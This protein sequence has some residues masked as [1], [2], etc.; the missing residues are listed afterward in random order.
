[1]FNILVPSLGQACY[2][3]TTHNMLCMDLTFVFE[4]FTSEK[5]FKLTRFMHA[6]ELSA[7]AQLNIL[8]VQAQFDQEKTDLLVKMYACLRVFPE[9][10]LLL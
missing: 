4:G 8:P 3:K 6:C 5:L 1:M 7:I 10:M 2:T 9:L